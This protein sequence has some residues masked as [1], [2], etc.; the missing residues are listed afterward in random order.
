MKVKRWLKQQVVSLFQSP[1]WLMQKLLFPGLLWRV[2]STEKVIYLTF[3][4]GPLPKLSPW[5]QQ[6]LSKVHAK[7][8]FFCVGENIQKHPGLFRQMLENGHAYG[9]H[10]FNHLN[11][12]Q[13]ATKIYIDNVAQA[14]AQAVAVAPAIA[15]KQPRLFRPPYGKLTP[16]QILLLKKKYKIIMWDVLTLDYSRLLTPEDC[17]KAAIKLTRP[18]SVIVFHENIKAAKNIKYVLP[19]Y[20]KHFHNKGYSFQPFYL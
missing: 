15:E 20:L 16:K 19:R 14:D 2:K 9:N 17:L 1:G 6:E 4:D 12:W 18:G 5:V 13:S 7:A 3:D 10:T 11:G 8:T